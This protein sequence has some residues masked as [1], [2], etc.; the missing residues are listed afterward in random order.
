MSIYNNTNPT[1]RNLSVKFANYDLPKLHANNLEKELYNIKS[2]VDKARFCRLNEDED[3]K[4]LKSLISNGVNSNS[5]KYNLLI[6]LSKAFVE[7]ATIGTEMP[8]SDYPKNIKERACDCLVYS[9]NKSQ[10]LIKSIFP[11][12]NNHEMKKRSIIEILTHPID[13][14]IDFRKEGDEKLIQKIK[15]NNEKTNNFRYYILGICENN[16]ELD[17]IKYHNTLQQ[18]YSIDYSDEAYQTDRIKIMKDIFELTLNGNIDDLMDNACEYAF[19]EGFENWKY[20]Q[21]DSNIYDWRF[22]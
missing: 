18:I 15:T 19:E 22:S 7:R 4:N 8:Y 16:G 11:T 9:I 5:E 10:N 2:K 21:F 17:I 13:S 3:F 6:G 14:I 12:G 1:L 20:K